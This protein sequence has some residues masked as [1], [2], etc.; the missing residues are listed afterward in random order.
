MILNCSANKLLKEKEHQQKLILPTL[1]FFFSHA[2]WLEKTAVAL[3]RRCCRRI[4]FKSAI[5]VA[6]IFTS[7]IA[8]YQVHKNPSA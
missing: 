1:F 7:G 5:A 8:E 2:L 6:L 3:N 4:V